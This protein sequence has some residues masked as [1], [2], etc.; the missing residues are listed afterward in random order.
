MKI[1]VI[2]CTHIPQA[3]PALP[4]KIHQV[5]SGLDIILH[6]GDVT[7][8]NT[9]R[10]LENNFTLTFAVAGEQ[11]SAELKKYVEPKRVVEFTNRRIGMIHG[12]RDETPVERR[13]FARLSSRF[14]AKPP[15]IDPIRY[16]LDQFDAVDAIVCGHTHRPYARMH[17]GVFVFNPGAAAP[18][19]G[20]RPCVGILDVQPRSI[21]GRIVYL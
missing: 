5:F 9:L 7:E 20:N 1:G 18:M 21:S 11:D 14:K 16:V 8:L 6:V 12:H 13:W 2:G 19:G 15:P 3:M 4:E 10:E 17:N